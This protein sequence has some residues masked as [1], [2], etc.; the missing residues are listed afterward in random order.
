MSSLSNALKTNSNNTSDLA[1]HGDITDITLA[2]KTLHSFDFYTDNQS[3]VHKVL[4]T[5]R[6]KVRHPPAISRNTTRLLPIHNHPLY[7][8]SHR[9]S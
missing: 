8:P 9:R 3:G 2:L 6:E 7:R 4:K 5:V 1:E